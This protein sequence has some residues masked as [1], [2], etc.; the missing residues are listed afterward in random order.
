MVTLTKRLIGWPNALADQPKLPPIRLNFN[1]YCTAIAVDISQAAAASGCLLLRR[2]AAPGL[3]NIAVAREEEER[4]GAV[5]V[6]LGG[7]RPR[8]RHLCF[9]RGAKG[10]AML[11]ATLRPPLTRPRCDRTTYEI[12]PIRNT[13]RNANE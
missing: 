4:K 3:V 13:H 7:D 12:G 6:V 11:A 9:G 8:P 2:P 10:Q 1:A 5:P